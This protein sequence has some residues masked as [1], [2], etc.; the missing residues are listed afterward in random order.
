MRVY[1]E[2]MD[3]GPYTN[4]VH[5]GELP[6]QPGQSLKLVYDFGDNWQF[7]VKLESVEPLP[8]K[9]KT[10]ILESHGKAPEQYPDTDW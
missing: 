9:A 5:I 8:R 6:L 1:H 2:Y 3:E 7:D 10:R 4:E